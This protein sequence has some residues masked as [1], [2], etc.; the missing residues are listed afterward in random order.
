MSGFCMLGERSATHA[1]CHMLIP[2]SRTIPS[3]VVRRQVA[4]KHPTCIVVWPTHGPKSPWGKC[5]CWQFYGL[6]S[7]IIVRT[8]STCRRPGCIIE[9][10]FC[11]LLSSRELRQRA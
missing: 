6:M 1:L 10:K 11:H 8:S 9:T 2:E 3:W 7:D 4:G 5:E